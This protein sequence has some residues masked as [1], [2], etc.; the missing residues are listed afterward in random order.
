MLRDKTFWVGVIAGV[1]LTYVYHRF[2]GIP[3]NAPVKP[4]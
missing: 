4:A 3:T 1:A 2:A